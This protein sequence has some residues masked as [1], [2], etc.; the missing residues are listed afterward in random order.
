MQRV[1]ARPEGELL[2]NHEYQLSVFD[3]FREIILSQFYSNNH[4]RNIGGFDGDKKRITTQQK[5]AH[6]QL[7]NQ[8]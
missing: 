6:T 7:M 1:L 2:D 8:M 3:F 5:L 4:V